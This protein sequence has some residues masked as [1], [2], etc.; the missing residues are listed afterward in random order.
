ML[1]RGCVLICVIWKLCPMLLCIVH[2]GEFESG[3]KV[4][5]LGLFNKPWL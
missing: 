3:Q 4:T 5:M 1:N 2:W